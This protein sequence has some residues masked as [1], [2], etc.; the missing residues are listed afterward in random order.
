MT[1]SIFTGTTRPVALI[2]DD[3]RDFLALA[4]K[5]LTNLGFQAHVSASG[6]DFLQK[7]NSLRPAVC[8]IDLRLGTA[9][10]GFQ[11]V[12]ELRLRQGSD[13]PLFVVSAE[14]DSKII[15]HAMEI[16]A[17]DYIVKPVDSPGLASKLSPYFTSEGIAV[18]RKPL[19]PVGRD[20]GSGMLTMDYDLL[21]VDEFGLTLAGP[22]LISKGT[23][24]TLAGPLLKQLTGASEKLLLTVTNSWIDSHREGAYVTY[25]EFSSGDP[26]LLTAVRRWLTS[27]Q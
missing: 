3:D 17:T 18:A 13:I 15:A 5:L 9:L 6:D 27:R 11:L 19:A 20:V 16:G 24:V 8:L 21:T 2:V 1:K 12:E 10:A 26:E 7:F 22:S 4:R 25:A 23:V 14:S